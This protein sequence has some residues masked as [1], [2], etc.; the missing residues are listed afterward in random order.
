MVLHYILR[1]LTTIY[2]NKPTYIFRDCVN[3]LYFLK[4]H[5]KLSTT[6]KSHPNKVTLAS[7][8]QMLVSDIQTTTIHKVQAYANIDGTKQTN[9]LA[10]KRP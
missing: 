6:Y 5:I 1:L 10:K 2:Q 8:A 7:M 9:K 4:N 3:V